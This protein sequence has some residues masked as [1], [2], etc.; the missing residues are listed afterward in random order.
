MRLAGPRDLLDH[1]IILN[2][3]HLKRLLSCYLL[4]Y[5]EDRI[6]SD[7]R[8]TRQ[9]A[10]LQRSALGPSARFNPFRDSVGCTIVMRWQLR[11]KSYFSEDH[12]LFLE[13]GRGTVHVFCELSRRVTTQPAIPDRR[14]YVKRK[15]ILLMQG[16]TIWRTTVVHCRNPMD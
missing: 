6:I 4:Y 10:G 16:A 1:V 15:Q 2:E 9:Q 11:L 7:S 5:H 12:T 13:P 8:R 14:A 3:R